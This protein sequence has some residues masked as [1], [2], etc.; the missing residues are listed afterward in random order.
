[1][2]DDYS[3]DVPGP[4]PWRLAAQGSGCSMNFAG[5]SRLGAD[6]LAQLNMP[7]IASLDA[8]TNEFIAAGTEYMLAQMASLLWCDT[9]I[10][11]HEICLRQRFVTAAQWFGFELQRCYTTTSFDAN[12]DDSTMAQLLGGIQG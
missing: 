10:V 2:T 9:S 7:G 8:A 12:Y 11:V 1:M 3:H 6:F 5:A 4:D